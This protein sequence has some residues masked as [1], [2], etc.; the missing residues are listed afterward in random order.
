MSWLSARS[1][2]GWAVT[3][4]SVSPVAPID[5]PA[6]T[7][8]ANGTATHWS[9]GVALAGATKIL[10]SGPVTPNISYG[11]GIAPPELVVATAVTE[12]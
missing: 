3:G 12:D 2:A 5:F 7:G 10:Y 8:G 6:P 11:V 4:N 9:V 1:A